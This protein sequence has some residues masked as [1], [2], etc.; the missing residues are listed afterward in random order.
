MTKRGISN[1]M[2]A[3]V[4]SLGATSIGCNNDKRIDAPVLFIDANHSDGNNV[5]ATHIDAV[6]NGVTLTVKNYMMRCS[7]SVDNGNASIAPTQTVIVL[8]GSIPVAAVATS[9]FEL[10]P[11]PWHDTVGD[12]GTGDQGAITGT[13][14]DASSAAVVLVGATGA[15]AWVCCPAANGTGCPT[16]NQCP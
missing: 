2:F 4:I 11:T 13:G 8:P 15:C 16:A 10:G 14:Q 7:V 5:D 1:A 12:I 6:P 9:G 3:A